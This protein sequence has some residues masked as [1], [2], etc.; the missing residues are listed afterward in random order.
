MSNAPDIKVVLLG[1]KNVGKTSIFNRYVYDEFGKTSMTIGAYFAM[2]QCRIKDKSYQLAIWDTA[3]EEK[4]DSLTNFYCR[5]AKA[6]IICYDIT[7]PPTFQNLQRWVDKISVEA[8]QNCAIVI[9]GNKLDLVEEN[10]SLR[11]V[12]FGDA[13]RYA[14]T[15]NA[16]AF[17][18]CAAS[19]KGVHEVFQKVVLTSVQRN[20]N[21]KS[22]EEESNGKKLVNLKQKGKES[23]C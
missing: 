18:V 11:R 5:N 20:S 8:E 14:K 9:V 13:K 1:H 2:K 23:C 7:S 17:E 6:A 12:D 21:S 3:G 16:E 15:I 4:F 22:P 19:G 10:P